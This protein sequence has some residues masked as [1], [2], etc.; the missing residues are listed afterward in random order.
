[1]R[2]NSAIILQGQQPDFVNTLAASDAAGYQ[3]A[4]IDRM[5][6]LNALY[7]DQG[8]NIL[9]G[10]EG[11]VNALA[12]HDPSLAFGVQNER[13]GQ[14]QT[15]LG[16]EATRESMANDRTRLGF[17]RQR[18]GIAQSQLRLA[19]EQARDR[20]TQAA[21]N[22]SAAEVASQREQLESVIEG[23]SLAR[24]EETYNQWLTSNGIDPS[25]YPFEQRELALASLVGAKE[26][27]DVLGGG[28]PADEYQ[29]YVQEE[30]QAGRQPLDRISYAQAKKGNGVSMTMPD[31]TVV[32]VGGSGQQGGPSPSSPEAMISSI[33]GILNDPALDRST[34][35][36]APLQ[37]VPGTPQRRFGARAS[38]LEGQAF[39]QAFE[40]LKGGGQI[41]EI[42]GQKATQA[43]GRLDTSQSA[44]D[45]RDALTELREIL[46]LGASRPQGW[47]ESQ[48]AESV[49]DFSTMPEADVINF[50]ASNASLA[51]IQAWN[52]RM[53]ELGK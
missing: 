2:T 42:E 20:V 1:M 29:R 51:E 25:Q 30:N 48:G 23:A 41:T 43:I 38:Q 36:F 39:L 21:A 13:L 32:S 8:A 50:D 45:Y 9:A 52:K 27:L 31:G 26:A 44:T 49:I 16:M 12:A 18:I 47:A 34:G 6:A 33:D 19:Q 11:A 24:D 22:L 3:A 14:E 10:E 28:E 53:D 7:R 35:I 17:E 4:E 40:S 5:N 46:V 15:R 37:S